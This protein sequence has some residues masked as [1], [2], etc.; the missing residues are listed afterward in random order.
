MPSLN[1]AAYIKICMESVLKQTLKDINII[2]VD[3]GSTDGTLEIL[4]EYEALDPRVKVI[5]SEKK[6]Y[7][8]Q[9]NLGIRAANSEYIGIVE[10][11]DY[12]EPNMFER[13]YNLAKATD[14]DY[15]KG[16]AQ[17]FLSL[18]DSIMYTEKF[19]VFPEKSSVIITD[20]AEIDDLVLRDYFLWKGIYKSELLADIRFNE[21]P[22][23]AYQD[24]G[25]L[26]Q[27]FTKATKAVYVPDEFYHYRKDNPNASGYNR[28]AFKFLIE[29][30]EF[31]DS[32]IKNQSK[33]FITALYCKMYRQTVVR[34]RMMAL[35]GEIWEGAE[36]QLDILRN[37]LIEHIGEITNA[38]KFLSN[39]EMKDIS[40]FIDS[41]MKLFNE[42]K[43]SEND[44][45]HAIESFVNKVKLYENVVVFGC[46]IYGKFVPAILA[47]KGISSIKAYSDNN[48]ELWGKNIYGITV[49][50]PEQ[51]IVKY[52]DALYIIANKS[53]YCEI[54]YQLITAGIKSDNI[55]HYN[56]GIDSQ[57]LSS[58]Y[59][60]KE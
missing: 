2:A 28:K 18:T 8:Y 38:A 9:M 29:E 10:T 52:N 50:S 31:T 42:I 11:D 47:A 51:A 39:E 56:L 25:F 3:A 27:V 33:N 35:S 46:G 14:A 40:L 23:A 5:V 19:A 1:V 59:L 17:M 34:I 24:I 36:T 45:N 13:L 32:F 58:Q 12:I 6:S 48:A 7:G 4:R 22:G 30:Y 26:V 60:K 49:E 53:Q 57:M 54:R 15:C 55:V 43:L 37:H 44:K 16:N 20:P 21:T 41:P